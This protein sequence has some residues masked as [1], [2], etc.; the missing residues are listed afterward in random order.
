MS[1]AGL[2]KTK[3]EGRRLVQQGGVRVDGRVISEIEAVVELSGEAVLQ[4][5]R[6]KFVRL[7]QV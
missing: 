4:I 7:V 3:S 6:R 2:I 1:D 5:G